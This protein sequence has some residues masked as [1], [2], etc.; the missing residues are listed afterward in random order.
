MD[1]SDYHYKIRPYH[2]RLIFIMIISKT[3]YGNTIVN[4]LAPE[5]CDYIQL[6]IIIFQLIIGNNSLPVGTRCEIT[7]T[8]MPKNLLNDKSTL[9]Q[10]LDWCRHVPWW[11]RNILWNCHQIIVSLDLIDVYTGSDNG[12]VPSDTKLLL[13][14]MQTKFYIPTVYG[15]TR[16]QWVN[17]L[18]PSDAYMRQ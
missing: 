9:V 3:I 18:R 2:D 6:K 13:E 14:P 1:L 7:L 8:W 16:G 10:V 15:V 12:L 17:S 4:S 11:L 5:W